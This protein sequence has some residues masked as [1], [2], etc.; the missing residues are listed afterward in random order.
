M[1]HLVECDQLTENRIQA[2]M[3]GKKIL[4]KV[5]DVL[6]ETLLK[7]GVKRV[8]GVAGD[9]LNGIT[10]SIRA[11]DGID[12][13]MVRHEEVAAFAAGGESQITG[14]L[15]LGGHFKSGHT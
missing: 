7:A 5:A 15:T 1:L 6:V 3:F 9:S 12:W 14:E 11:Y 4:A 2:K 13:M 8:Y 10:E